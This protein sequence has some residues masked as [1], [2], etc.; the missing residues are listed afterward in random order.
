MPYTTSKYS[1]T[2]V[3]YDSV[4]HIANSDYNKHYARIVELHMKASMAVSKGKASDYDEE[5]ERLS[6]AQAKKIESP[7]KAYGRYL[8]AEEHGFYSVAKG[9][10]SKYRFLTQTRKDKIGNI[11]DGLD[12]L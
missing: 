11:L 2:I 10:L 8:V 7:E 12:D 6:L 1:N 3:P 9:F 5:A 4:H